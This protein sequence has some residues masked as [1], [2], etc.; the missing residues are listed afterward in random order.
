MRYQAAWC[1]AVVA[2][3]A[4]GDVILDF[5]PGDAIAALNRSNLVISG[6][7]LINTSSM[8]AVAVTPAENV[9]LEYVECYLERG[10]T[11]NPT[12]G[13]ELWASN[14]SGLPDRNTV[15]ETSIDTSPA[16]PVG[17]TPLYAMIHFPG[18]ALLAQ[19]T[20]YWLVFR[21]R[22]GPSTS[23]PQ[24]CENTAGRTNPAYPW[25]WS[26]NGFL[27][28]SP[29]ISNYGPAVRVHAMVM[30]GCAADF[31]NDGGVDGADVEAFFTAWEAGDAGS[32][33]NSDG[34]I[35]GADVEAFFLLWE[36][37]GC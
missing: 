26:S 13:V 17:V 4:S 14:A 11:N 8:V 31:N 6:N 2:S 27:T 30:G 3:A 9:R 10:N 7:V 34:G 20:T 19:G 24:L 32:D 28:A 12:V 15:L 1:A 22:A 21:L 36:A 33:V 18:N 23:T 16:I 37:G 25:R 35:D 29:A 5:M